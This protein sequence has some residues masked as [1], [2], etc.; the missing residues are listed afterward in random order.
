M[1]LTVRPPDCGITRVPTRRS[2]HVCALELIPSRLSV[3]ESAAGR[4]ISVVRNVMPVLAVLRGFRPNRRRGL[5]GERSVFCS[6]SRFLNT[7]VVFFV[8]QVLL[9]LLAGWML[10]TNGSPYAQIHRHDDETYF[11]DEHCKRI[12]F[13]SLSD[14]PTI[15]LSVIVPAYNEQDRRKS[16]PS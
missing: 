14:S 2:E 16:F 1:L 11:V 5:R 9:L 15:E 4:S 13:P 8:L 6:L 7:F 10:F 12:K 3:V